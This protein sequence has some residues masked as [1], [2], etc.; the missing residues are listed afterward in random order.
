MKLYDFHGSS[1]AFRVRIAL[2]F[3]GVSY[4]RIPV[5]LVA[6]EQSQPGYR[7]LN[8]TALVPSLVDRTLVFTESLAIIEY[9]DETHPRPPLL[10]DNPEGRARV[11]A[12]A[13][14][15][16]SGIQPLH[17]E[18]TENFLADGMGVPRNKVLD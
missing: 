14:S 11:R 5:D 7:S 2:N 18:R 12:I 13:S 10:P 9:L 16:A 6:G 15:I 3:K 8:P 4:D 17:T 1:C